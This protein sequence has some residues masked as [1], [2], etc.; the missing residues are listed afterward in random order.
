ME[1]HNFFFCEEKGFLVFLKKKNH[2]HPV[3]VDRKGQVYQTKAVLDYHTSFSTT[4]L[5]IL[6]H[7]INRGKTHL[8]VI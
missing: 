8:V 1:K 2:L 4:V 5:K 7:A 3:P 6:L